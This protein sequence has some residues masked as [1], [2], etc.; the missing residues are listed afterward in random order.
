MPRNACTLVG[1]AVADVSDDL[2]LAGTLGTMSSEDSAPAARRHAPLAI[3][4]VSTQSC[5]GGA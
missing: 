2:A 1:S 4:A 5:T 3:I